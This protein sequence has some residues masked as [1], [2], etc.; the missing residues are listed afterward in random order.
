MLLLSLENVL[1]FAKYIGPSSELPPAYCMSFSYEFRTLKKGNSQDSRT[2]LENSPRGDANTGEA[3]TGKIEGREE[4]SVGSSL[5]LVDERIKVN[6]EPLYAQITGLTEMIDHLI[7]NNLAK[8]AIMVSFRGIQQPYESPY[9][10]VPGFS[11]FPTVATV[12]TAGYSLDT[13][14]EHGNS[15]A[16]WYSSSVRVGI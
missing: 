9:S 12:T 11:R 6:L 16:P 14:Y 2:Q 1:P 10:E 4:I 7:R 8:E 15:D 5:K 13:W 3:G